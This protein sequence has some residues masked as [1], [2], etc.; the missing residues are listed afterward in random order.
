MNDI[1]DAL[2]AAFL[3]EEKFYDEG[4]LK[5]T[6]VGLSEGSTEG[7]QTGN[8]KGQPIGEEL[9]FYS[10]FTSTFVAVSEK[11]P[12][13]FSERQTK[14][15]A[16]LVTLIEKYPL[17]DATDSQVISKLQLIRVK[18]KH[19]VDILGLSDCVQ[20]RVDGSVRLDNLVDDE[21]LEENDTPI[22]LDF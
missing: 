6:E 12:E 10:G 4:N 19:F 3:I 9:G 20:F 13:Q 11:H 8:E 16:R 17:G 22:D 14:S 2:E 5:G 21:K 18:F 1:N 7:V 15:L